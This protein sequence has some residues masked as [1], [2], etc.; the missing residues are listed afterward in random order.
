MLFFASEIDEKNESEPFMKFGEISVAL[1]WTLFGYGEP[2]SW[3][4]IDNCPQNHVL[5]ELVST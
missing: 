4:S 5:E 3:Y 2:Q 1:Y